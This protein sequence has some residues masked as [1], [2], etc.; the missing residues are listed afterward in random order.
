MTCLLAV[1]VCLSKAVCIPSSEGASSLV[2]CRLCCQNGI[3]LESLAQIGRG[4]GREAG[5]IRCILIGIVLFTSSS[6]FAR[7]GKAARL[8]ISWRSLS[9]ESLL[10]DIRRFI[11]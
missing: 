7:E 4:Q 6:V 3:L 10:G 8:H 2:L 5:R 11:I 9:K 1:V